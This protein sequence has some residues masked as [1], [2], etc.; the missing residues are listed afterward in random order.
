MLVHKPEPGVFLE[1]VGSP[2]E[3]GADAGDVLMTCRWTSASNGD[4]VC[5]ACADGVLEACITMGV[6]WVHP[7]L[8][9]T[10]VFD[11]LA[12]SAELASALRALCRPEGRT[13]LFGGRR[14][15]RAERMLEPFEQLVE[16]GLAEPVSSSSRAAGGSAWA[17]LLA[18][19]TV[20]SPGVHGYRPTG[21]G[22]RMF[23]ALADVAE[24]WSSRG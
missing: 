8:V 24:S 20:R 4:P 2:T 16:L 13:V 15:R 23:D 3:M 6:R 1:F 21:Y 19:S 18:D 17:P 14:G 9:G 5:S 11:Q 12:D 7:S 22:L 10:S